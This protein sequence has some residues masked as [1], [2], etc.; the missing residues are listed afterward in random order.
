VMAMAKTPS[1][2]VSRRLVSVNRSPASRQGLSRR[3]SA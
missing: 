3:Q 2:N 1:Q